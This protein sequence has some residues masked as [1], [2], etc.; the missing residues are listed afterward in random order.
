M[1]CSDI[2]RFSRSCQYMSIIQT[3]QRE[4]LCQSLHCVYWTQK[5]PAEQGTATE[6]DSNNP[7][8]GRPQAKIQPLPPNPGP[9]LR[10]PEKSFHRKAA[11]YRSS[12][13]RR[14]TTLALQVQK[15]TGRAL[16]SRP[17]ESAP[18]ETSKMQHN[19]ESFIKLSEAGRNLDRCAFH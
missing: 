7:Q 17:Q 5:L 2:K 12:L 10:F 8:D 11:P 13:I 3:I 19:S 18:I 6:Q 1:I 9:C 15:A 16:H 4:I 14:S